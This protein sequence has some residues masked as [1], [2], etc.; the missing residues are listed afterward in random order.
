MNSMSLMHDVERAHKIGREIT[1]H[2]ALGDPGP[3][4]VALVLE[5]DYDLIVLDAP[6]VVENGGSLP[7]WEQYIREHASCAVCLLS[8]PA[9]QREVVE[10]TP[11]PPS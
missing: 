5:H 10:K 7:A 8:L 6:A 2:E 11:P 9:I 3:A 4:I 1:V